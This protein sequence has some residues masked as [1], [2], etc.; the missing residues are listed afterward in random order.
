MCYNVNIQNPKTEK[1]TNKMKKIIS[2]IICAALCFTL[3][4]GLTSCNKGKTLDEVKEAGELVI[5][6]SPDF[7]P[8][9]NLEGGEVVGIEVEL[10][11]MI[12]KELGVELVLEQ[13]N[14]DA[15]GARALLVFCGEGLPQ[16]RELCRRQEVLVQSMAV[17]GLC[18]PADA[19]SEDGT[20][21]IDEN[22]TARAR[23]V[24]VIGS[25]QGVMLVRPADE[26]APLCAGDRVLVSARRI[27]D[28]K[29][30]S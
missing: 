29:V 18:I 5:A 16:G 27:Y 28:G 14:F 26:Q 20:V 21:F 9:E 6:T 10:M 15:A 2:L 12:C 22:G 30:L 1:E 13:I 7:P 23:R 19:L 25:E 24:E 17:T 11:E 8:F 4:F 3:V